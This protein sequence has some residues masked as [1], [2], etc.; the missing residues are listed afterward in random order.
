[1]WGVDLLCGGDGWYSSG[2]E[3]AGREGLRSPAT[4]DRP[5]QINKN[6]PTHI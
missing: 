6:H 3:E 1:M 4:K 2:Y 5:K